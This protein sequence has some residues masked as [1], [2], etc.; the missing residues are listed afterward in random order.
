MSSYHPK[1]LADILKEQIPPIAFENPDDDY[2]KTTKISDFLTKI[3]DIF[4]DRT[5]QPK[6]TMQ[7]SKFYQLV[8]YMDVEDINNEV[9]ETLDNIFNYLTPSE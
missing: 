7:K 6:S 8:D 1:E 3:F 9:K 2:W 5:D 4:L